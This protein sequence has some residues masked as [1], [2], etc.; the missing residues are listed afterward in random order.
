MNRLRM[1]GGL[2][3]AA[4]ANA[5]SPD[6]S[7]S[8]SVSSDATSSTSKARERNKRNRKAVQSMAEQLLGRTIQEQEEEGVDG[9]LGRVL[10]M[11]PKEGPDGRSSP[12][13]KRRQFNQHHQ[14][15]AAIMEDHLGEFSF[16]TKD[17][18]RFF[19]LSCPHVQ[20]IIKALANSDLAF[21]KPFRKDIFGNEGASMEAKVLLP[22]KTLACYGV[23]DHCFMAGRLPDVPFHGA[24][25]LHHILQSDSSV[26]W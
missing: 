10:F 19:R 22:I 21:Y 16:Y 1:Q 23:G 24:D 5:S 18:K 26:V 17:F 3:L 14:A 13:S 6:S 12:R 4:L 2:P 20:C 25:L 11:K 8:L 7:L 15:H 9:N